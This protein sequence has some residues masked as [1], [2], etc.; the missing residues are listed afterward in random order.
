[1]IS[2]HCRLLVET[3]LCVGIGKKKAKAHMQKEYLGFA[4]EKKDA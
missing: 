2:P 1:M 4:N 3:T